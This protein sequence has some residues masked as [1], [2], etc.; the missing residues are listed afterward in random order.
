MM[1]M[2]KVKYVVRVSTFR[3]LL[4][5]SVTSRMNSSMDPIL[6]VFPRSSQNNVCP[7]KNLNNMIS[8]LFAWFRSWI[9][10]NWLVQFSIYP[11]STTNC[12]YPYFD[13]YLGNY[14]TKSQSCIL[15]Q[16][17]GSSYISLLI[18]RCTSYCMLLVLFI[19]QDQV[20][21]SW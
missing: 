18:F 15:V 12:D 10:S 20:T 4:G 11:V 19:S 16:I 17:A 2:I 13:V 6:S 5:T 14:G 9:V 3:S 21:N 1:P 7:T 8:F